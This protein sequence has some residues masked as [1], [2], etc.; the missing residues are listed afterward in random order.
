MWLPATEK[1]QSNVRFD[2]DLPDT[3]EIAPGSSLV[4]RHNDKREGK[5]DADFR[6]YVSLEAAVYE[7]LVAARPAKTAAVTA[8]PAQEA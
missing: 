5:N 6:I 7:A 2:R 1:G 8:T 3:L 4:V